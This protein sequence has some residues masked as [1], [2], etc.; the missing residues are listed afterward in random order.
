M[1]TVVIE[2]MMPISRVFLNQSQKRVSLSA[3][4]LPDSMVRNSSFDP[5]SV[6]PEFRDAEITDMIGNTA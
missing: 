1:R 6:P 3:R 4:K 2:V 5:V